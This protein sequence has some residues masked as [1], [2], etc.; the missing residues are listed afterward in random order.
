LY[1]VQDYSSNIVSKE[2]STTALKYIS[3][4]AGESCY[5]SNSG[6]FPVVLSY[7]NGTCN[8]VYYNEKNEIISTKNNV[9]YNNIEIK[10]GYKVKITA[11]SND[12]ANYYI[13][14]DY[15]KYI[16]NS[17][18]NKL[19]ISSFTTSKTSPQVVKTAV[20][21]TTKVSGIT[22][23]AQYKYYRYLNGNYATIKDWS[24]S[25]SIAIAP[26]TAGKY[27]VYVAVK[28][29]SGNTVR[30]NIVFEFKQQA[31]LAISSFTASKTSP[32][33][34][35][36][37]VTLTTKVSGVTGTAQYK[38]YR[39]L[40]G[41]YG[42]IKDWSTSSSITIAPSTAGKYD[43]WVAVKDG[44][45]KTVKKNIAFE[46]KN[47]ANLGIS[48]FTAS[49]TSPQAVKTAVTLTTKVSGVTGTAQYKYY[50]YLN[51][52]YGQIKD[53][54]TSSSITI[55]PSTAGKYDLWVAVKDSSG[56]TV[57]KNIVFTFR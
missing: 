27:D 5:L 51:G 18:E 39:Y 23:T 15:S 12:G 28:D 57:K 56:K 36:T 19:A 33:P 4:K 10:S 1:V 21:F 30:K 46:F 35:K 31:N 41:V 48:S 3:I 16:A 44:S 40:N 37:A 43:L 53:W 29:G 22:G 55:A 24:S 2:I 52:A 25:S 8:I 14:N 11:V 38:Y 20:T 34:I 26:S 45:G 50:R 6:N 49:K 17:A 47:Q 9:S 42:Q 54:S 7:I 13:P 32:Q